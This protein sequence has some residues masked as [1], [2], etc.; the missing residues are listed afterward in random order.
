MHEDVLRFESDAINAEVLDVD[1]RGEVVEPVCEDLDGDLHGI[2][3]A[4]G[5]D[6]NESDPNV[7]VGAPELCNGQDDDCDG[8]HDEDYVGLG[9]TCEVGLG[10]CT[11]PGFK[12][13]APDE[14]SLTCSVNPWSGVNEL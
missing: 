8:L 11:A 7:Y 12:V 13:C 4:A 9:E 14:A 2:A 6:C 1:V 10:A 3:C 5:G